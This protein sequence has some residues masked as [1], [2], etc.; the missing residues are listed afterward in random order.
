VKRPF[1]KNSEQSPLIKPVRQRHVPQPRLSRLQVIP[2]GGE[3]SNP[4]TLADQIANFEAAMTAKQLAQLLSVS[5]VSVFKLA[6]RGTLPSF[7]VGTC[8]RFCPAAIARWLRE[9]G[10]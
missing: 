10:G 6:K 4:E 9:C 8:V 1:D 2:H 7:R 5:A 3:R